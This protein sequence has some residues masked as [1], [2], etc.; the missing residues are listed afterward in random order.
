MRIFKTEGLFSLKNENENR[1]ARW[2]SFVTFATFGHCELVFLLDAVDLLES[3]KGAISNGRFLFLFFRTILLL[4]LFDDN[5][6]QLCALS[7]INHFFASHAARPES[8]IAKCS[9]L[10]FIHNRMHC[11]QILIHLIPSKEPRL[12]HMSVDCI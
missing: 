5:E 7:I 2:F 11:R 9:R 6:S 3:L 12:H 1:H 4:L 10:F 8:L